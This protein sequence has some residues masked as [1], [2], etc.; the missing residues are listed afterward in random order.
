[1]SSGKHIRES[2]LEPPLRVVNVGVAAF[3]EVLRERQVAVI[4]VDWRPPQVSDPR[5]A[6]L[7]SKLG[8]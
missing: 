5:L 7:L 3:A 2:L 6:D 1:M 4:E 8:M